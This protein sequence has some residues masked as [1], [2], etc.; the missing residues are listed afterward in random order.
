[1]ERKIIRLLCILKFGCISFLG[2]AQEAELINYKWEVTTY[3][4]HRL[5]LPHEIVNYEILASN[6][7]G[8]EIQIIPN[9]KNQLW[10]TLGKPKVKEFQLNVIEEVPKK[11][12]RTHS[13]IVIVKDEEGNPL[14]L[15][16]PTDQEILIEINRISKKKEESVT[17]ASVQK[18]SNTISSPPIDQ[19]GANNKPTSNNVDDLIASADKYFKEQNF[20]EAEII[21]N[22]VVKLE[23]GN[24]HIISQLEKINESKKLANDLANKEEKYAENFKKAEDYKKSG[25]WT[26]AKYYY[27]EALKYA[28]NPKTVQNQID[29]VEANEKEQKLKEDSFNSLKV[30][31]ETANQNKDFETAISNWEAALTIFPNDKVALNQLELS[32]KG[33]Q[34]KKSEELQTQAR[35]EKLKV[36][37]EIQQKLALIDISIRNKDFLKARDDLAKASELM[38]GDVRIEQKI[39]EIDAAEKRQID[40]AITKEKQLIDQQYDLH[41]ANSQNLLKAGKY[42]DAIAQLEKAQGIK[43]TDPYPANQI[44]I[45]IEAESRAKEEDERKKKNAELAALQKEYSKQILLADK[46]LAANKLDEAADAYLAANKIM[47]ENPYPETK[48][49]VIEDKRKALMVKMEADKKRQEELRIIEESYNNALNEGDKLISLEEFDE[50]ISKYK[51][52]LSIKPKDYV[53][54]GKI[55]AATKK[56]SEVL[57]QRAIAKRLAEEKSRDSINGLGDAAWLS[58]DIQKAKDYFIKSIELYPES[59]YQAKSQLRYVEGKLKEISLKEEIKQNNEEYEMLITKADKELVEGDFESALLNAKQA[60]TLKPEESKPKSIIHLLTDPDERKRLELN[61][62]RS[63]SNKLVDSAQTLFDKGRYPET[64]QLLDEAKKL[65]PQNN[66]IDFLYGQANTAIS[67]KP[68]TQKTVVEIK[69]TFEEGAKSD[70]RNFSRNR[71]PAPSVKKQV[72]STTQGNQIQKGSEQLV[73]SVK[74][75]FENKSDSSATKADEANAGEKSQPLKAIVDEKLQE[76]INLSTVVPNSKEDKIELKSQLS[77]IPYSREEL[78]LKFPG[79]NFDEVPYGQKFTMEYFSE[80]EKATNLEK[81]NSLREAQSNIPVRDSINLVLAQLE[82]LSFGVNNAYFRIKISNYSLNK[83]FAAGYMMLSIERKNGESAN[84]EPCYI[85]EFPVVMPGN[86]ATFFY[87]S[88]QVFLKDEDKLIFNLFDRKSTNRFKIELPGEIYNKEYDK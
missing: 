18:P 72:D 26:Y 40:L 55:N 76:T 38:A 52:A 19:S 24:P 10:I 88:K 84:F 39:K 28:K 16:F 83:D 21:Y 20:K 9:T 4:K 45:I 53:A 86:T 61:L 29:L 75:E 56:K 71:T 43:P 80:V 49:K 1:M 48:L 12:P 68:A 31:A 79:I 67:G 46:L 15:R 47:P 44:K 54:I 32:R 81:C 69:M 74:K 33:L 64:V 34:N 8:I 36:E 6:S 3:N 85:S 63:L 70:G 25:E 37:N 51:D 60:S 87:V 13:F 17:P 77:A 57:E 59:N 27:K 42:S 41:V 62:N 22:Q 11:G 5:V 78:A 65:W 50:G 73:N 30:K 82:N 66:R 14:S 7:E 23:P 58:G 35:I 2:Y